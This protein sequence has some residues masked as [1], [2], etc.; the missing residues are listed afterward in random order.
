[1][2]EAE[3]QGYQP[4]PP[5]PP[6]SIHYKR[7]IV[8]CDGTGQSAT[9]DGK[10]TV[11]TNVTRFARSLMTSE[12]IP[13]IEADPNTE[14]PAQAAWEVQQVVL[15]QTGV[16]T[17]GVTGLSDGLSGAFGYGVDLHI[18]EAYTFF[19]INYEAGDRLFLFGFSR[20]AF[21]A[22][23]IASLICNAGLVKK[24]YLQYL[25]MI[26]EEYMK[27]R[28]EKDKRNGFK[29]WLKTEAEG[30]YKIEFHTNVEIWH[31]GVWDTVGSLGV[32][33]TWISNALGWNPIWNEHYGYHDTSFPIPT[34][35]DSWRGYIITSSQALALDETRISFSPT[36]LYAPIQKQE[37]IQVDHGSQFN[38]VWFPGVHTDVGGGYERAY[39]DISD[40]AFA[41][42]VDRCHGQ[43]ELKFRPFEELHEEMKQTS[44]SDAERS[45]FRLFTSVPPEPTDCGWAMSKQH[46]EA[47]TWKFK[48]GGTMPRTPGQYFLDKKHD[49]LKTEY[50][51]RE[52][53]HVSV[54]LRMMKD[55]TWKPAALA[56]FEL[57]KDET[58]YYWLKTMKKTG[59]QI[60]LDEWGLNYGGDLGDLLRTPEDNALLDDK[61]KSLGIEMVKER[62]SWFLSWLWG[63]N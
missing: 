46:D 56:G 18:K 37:D 33:R 13:A 41:W 34:D 39:H 21:T 28:D 43:G 30:K 23:A 24:R 5:P 14:Q 53:I 11:P 58:G 22:R 15:Y 7:L 60:R 32:P 3:Y 44:L 29:E 20:G 63:G 6:E 2:S 52:L 59:K 27:R 55:P 35:R 19:S 47:N 17:G 16:G 48:L 54:R 45:K 1:M 25:P 61:D 49:E 51:T 36:L 4:P 38:Q 57:K 40:I 62:G 31:L 10:A 26:Y 8:C 9:G 50:D 12:Y 42:M